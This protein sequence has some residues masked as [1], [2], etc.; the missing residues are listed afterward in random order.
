M[1][2]PSPYSAYTQRKLGWMRVLVTC[3]KIGLRLVVPDPD[4]SLCTKLHKIGSQCDSGVEKSSKNRFF[5]Y[6]VKF[7]ESP[8]LQKKLSDGLSILRSLIFKLSR[9]EL[10]SLLSGVKF[11]I[12]KHIQNES[13]RQSTHSTHS[14]FTVYRLNHAR[15]I[16]T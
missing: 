11:V 13:L 14:S 2:L 15:D 16:F 6:K 5:P 4:P 10:Y 7:A 9:S 1:D 8:L 12:H 3:L